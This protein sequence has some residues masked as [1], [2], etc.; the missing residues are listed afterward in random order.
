MHHLATWMGT[1]LVAA[2]VCTTAACSEAAEERDA[3]GLTAAGSA[4][5]AGEEA[6]AGTSLAAEWSANGFEHVEARYEWSGSGVRDHVFEPHLSLS[7]PETDD[8]I[9]SS[10]CVAGGKVE[11]RFYLAPPKGMQDG[12]ATLRIETDTSPATR[13]YP[14]RY[15]ADGQYDGFAILQRA[16]DPMFAEMKVG[17]WAYVQIGEG[18]DAAKLRISLAGA[19]RALGAF[20]PACTRDARKTLPASDTTA[21][22][23]ACDD[24]RTVTASYIGND[25]DTPVA[26]LVID[27]R[28]VLLSQAI[29]GSGARY[30]GESAGV[31]ITWLTKADEGF[32]AMGDTGDAAGESRQTCRC[33]AQ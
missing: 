7:V 9:W 22:A 1:A 33:S 11:T 14:A 30:E 8:A 6:K 2:L 27:G 15:V 25:T 23:Y 10:S 29:A 32:L 18:S 5:V 21:I 28:V 20:L 13:S 3:P 19:G 12:K 26:R 4:T 24:G 31:R 16:D 17:K